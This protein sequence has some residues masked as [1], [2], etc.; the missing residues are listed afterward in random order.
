LKKGGDIDSRELCG[1]EKDFHGDIYTESFTSY[2]RN[3]TRTKMKEKEQQQYRA[4][5]RGRPL[6]DP[7]WCTARRRFPL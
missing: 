1:E 4:I 2:S 6:A 3:Y 5:E 7:D